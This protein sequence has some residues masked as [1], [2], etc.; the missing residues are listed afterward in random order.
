MIVLELADGEYQ[1][2]PAEVAIPTDDGVYITYDA[3]PG[4]DDYRFIEDARIV[5]TLDTLAEDVTVPDD[6]DA[7]WVDAL[8]TE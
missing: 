2:E 6:A 1:Q 5:G 3:A 4:R 7:D 8:A